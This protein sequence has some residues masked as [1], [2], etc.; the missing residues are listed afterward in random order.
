MRVDNDRLRIGV[1]DHTYALTSYKRIEFVLEFRAEIVPLEFM[2]LA[3]KPQRGVECN[4]AGTLGA[5]VRIVV[6]A[7]KQV[8]DNLRMFHGA[9][10]AS[11]R[12][13]VI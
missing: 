1:A 2:N 6:C 13:C 8:I 9:E 11:H 10:K 4:H 5:K 7:V 12:N 3:V